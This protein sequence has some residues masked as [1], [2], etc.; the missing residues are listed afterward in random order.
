MGN[1]HVRSTGLV[2]MGGHANAPRRGRVRT[3]C[4]VRAFHQL[5]EE[6]GLQ[7]T[8]TVRELLPTRETGVGRLFDHQPPVHHQEG[9]PATDIGGVGRAQICH[10]VACTGVADELFPRHDQACGFIGCDGADDTD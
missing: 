3:I 1:S 10:P 2:A 9:M 8:D 6:T 7:C 4:W 5:F